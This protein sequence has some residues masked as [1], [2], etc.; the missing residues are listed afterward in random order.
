[1]R[2]IGLL[3]V[4]TSI[5]D[6]K[7]ILKSIFT[8]TLHKCDGINDDQEP[9]ACEN[10]KRF[11]KQRIATHIVEIDYENEANEELHYEEETDD[12]S[13]PVASTKYMPGHETIIR[14]M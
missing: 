13:S 14:R 7:T 3:V 10:A 11:L 2:A 12:V 4:S 8:T 6:I 5:G 1:M 9:T